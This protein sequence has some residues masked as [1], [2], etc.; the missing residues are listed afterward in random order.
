MT[1]RSTTQPTNDSRTRSEPR[2]NPRSI[3]DR[4]QRSDADRVH[5]LDV[6]P[7]GDGELDDK[8]DEEGENK[9]KGVLRSQ[10]H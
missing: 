4:T 10:H 3:R 8:S 9:G 5:E 6:N 1:R 2:G 7:E